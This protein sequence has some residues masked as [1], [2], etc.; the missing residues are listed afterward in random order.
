[1]YQYIKFEV[2]IWCHK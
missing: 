2:I 1:M